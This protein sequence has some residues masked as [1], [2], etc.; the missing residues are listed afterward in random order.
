M[1]VELPI[2]RGVKCVLCKAD[3]GCA[4]VS[5][6]AV[7]GVLCLRIRSTDMVKPREAAL[8][9]TA[10]DLLKEG[11]DMHQGTRT[12]C[13][14]H[15]KAPTAVAATTCTSLRRAGAFPMLPPRIG[16]GHAS[17]QEVETA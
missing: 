12:L 15:N 11:L 16:R 6:H 5:L 2:W 17:P 9:G 8:R 7:M 3:T 10:A 14:A 1:G 4:R 13:Q